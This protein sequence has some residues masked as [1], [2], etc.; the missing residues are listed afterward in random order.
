M[1]PECAG[2]DAT[3]QHLAHQAA[4]VCEEGVLHPLGPAL[5][6]WCH[7]WSEIDSP[8]ISWWLNVH[9]QRMQDK[10]LQHPAQ[11]FGTKEMERKTQDQT[12]QVGEAKQPRDK[13]LK[14]QL[15]A[16]FTENH[17]ECGEVHRQG[18]LLYLLIS[19]C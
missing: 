16:E 19:F 18:P 5:A 6:L 14:A 12:Y 7:C 2:F 11:I 4:Y 9:L 17:P 8:H 3:I 15:L 10:M 1:V 13:G